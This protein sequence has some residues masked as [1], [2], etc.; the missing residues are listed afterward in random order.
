M[1]IANRQQLLLIVAGT[2]AVLLVADRVAL[3][4]L[5]DLWKSRAKQIT[6]LRKQLTQGTALL[7][8]D[9]AIRSRWDFMQHN[10]LPIDPPMAEQ[11]LLRSFDQWARSS[12]ANITLITPQWKHEDEYMTLECRVDAAGDMETLSRFLYDIERDPMAL[13]LDSVELSA[14]DEAGR[15]MTIAVQINGLVLAP[16]V[17]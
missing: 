15:Q 6:E 7:Q 10:T 16:G 17:P 13:K 2:A 14:H 3:G 5:L 4:P 8:R 12:R 9:Q 11:Q 1:K